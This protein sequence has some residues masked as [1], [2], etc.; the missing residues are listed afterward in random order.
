MTFKIFYEWKSRTSKRVQSASFWKRITHPVLI[1]L[2]ASLKKLTVF[3]LS[4][5]AAAQRWPW[6]LHSWGFQIT[7]NEASQSVGLLWMSDQFRRRDL[8]LTTHNTNDIQ[9]S[10]TPAGFEPA[11]SAGERAAD[12]RLRPRGHWDRK[13]FTIWSRK[14][15]SF[16]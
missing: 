15:L 1:Y 6:P 3:H 7:H 2:R 12:L 16:R 5:G 9:T 4:C 10:M 13:Q 11:I 14:S 8:Y